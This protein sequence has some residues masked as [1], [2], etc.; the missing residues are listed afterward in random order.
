[1]SVNFSFMQSHSH[2]VFHSAFQPMEGGVTGPIGHNALLP[3][4]QQQFVGGDAPAQIRIQ[5]LEGALVKALAV[6]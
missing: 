3:V 1:M 4:Q 5:N 6:N 2:I